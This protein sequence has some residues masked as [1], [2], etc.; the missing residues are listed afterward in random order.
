MAFPGAISTA[1]SA[2]TCTAFLPA[3][4]PSTG[5]SP[6]NPLGCIFISSLFL[7]HPMS[8]QALWPAPSLEGRLSPL[9]CSAASWRALKHRHRALAPE[10]LFHWSAIPV[11]CSHPILSLCTVANSLLT[12]LPLPGLPLVLHLCFLLI[13]C[14]SPPPRSKSAKR[15]STF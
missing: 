13:S 4:S 12:R 9:A 5:P 3:A 11:S 10:I 6:W 1:P 15:P 8:H 14:Q 2:L 7:P